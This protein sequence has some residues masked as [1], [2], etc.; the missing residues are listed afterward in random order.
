MSERPLF[1]AIEELRC[2]RED[3]Q[4]TTHATFDGILDQ[5]VS[6]FALGT[7]LGD[8]IAAELPSVEFD[9]WWAGAK[10]TVVGM[11]GSGR[12]A[13][14]IDRRTRVAMQRA[15]LL[16]M[17][18][19]KTDV[20]EFAYHFFSG[21]N[22]YDEFIR[23]FVNQVIEPFHRDLVAIIAPHIQSERR[24]LAD[25][26]GER[27]STQR[28]PMGAASFVASSRIE[29]FGRL[30][31]KAGYDLRKLIR[32]CEE[33]NI[34]YAY[35]CWFAVAFLTRSLLDHIPPAFGRDSFAEVAAQHPGK[36]FKAAATA[37]ESFARKVADNHLHESLRGTLAL[38][39]ETQVYS[40]PALDLVLAE[41]ERALTDAQAHNHTLGK[42]S[43]VSKEVR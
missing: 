42:G 7:L 22:R 36:S 31:G 17:A 24:G 26:D 15:L 28:E 30:D 5:Y 27:P 41:L 9:N 1:D 33:L 16:Y 25:Q 19:G 18:E 23:A 10:G 4:R 11:V 12:L 14:P 8:L 6:V 43:E 39:N 40:A 21:S 32:L 20:N 29:T 34:A 2:Y 35:R 38:P 3:L 37:L 13:W